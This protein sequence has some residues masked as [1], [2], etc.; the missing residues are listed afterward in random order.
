[1]YSK[2]IHQLQLTEPCLVKSHFWFNNFDNI[3]SVSLLSRCFTFRIKELEF[4]SLPIKLILYP[5]IVPIIPNR[6]TTVILESRLDREITIGNFITMLPNSNSRYPD[7][8]AI[9]FSDDDD[10]ICVLPSVNI[11]LFDTKIT[12]RV[13]I[14]ENRIQFASPLQL[15]YLG[16]TEVSGRGSTDR[17]WGSLQLTLQVVFTNDF[18]SELTTYLNAELK[19][20]VEDTVQHIESANDTLKAT[21]KQV[22]NLKLDLQK[23]Y[24][25]LYDIQTSLDNYKKRKIVL[26]KQRDQHETILY[27][28]LETYWNATD[29]LSGSIESVC[30]ITE[31][32]RACKSGPVLTLCF[33]PVTM[34]VPKFC[35]YY[36]HE[37]VTIYEKKKIPVRICTYSRNQLKEAI[38]FLTPIGLTSNRK[39]KCKRVTVYETDWEPLAHTGTVLKTRPCSVKAVKNYINETCNYTSPCAVYEVDPVCDARNEECYDNRTKIIEN[40][41][42][43]NEELLEDIRMRRHFYKLALS[44]LVDISSK[45]AILKL[46]NISKMEEIEA[47]YLKIQISQESE[48]V[49]NKSYQSIKIKNKKILLFR[50]ELKDNFNSI[51][52]ITDVS[53]DVT[54]ETQTPVIVPLNVIYEIISRRTTHEVRIVVDVSATDDLVKKTIYDNIYDD[55]IDNV[56]GGSLRK[57][58]NVASSVL[59]TDIF[60]DNCDLQRSII[61]YLEQLNL[62][63]SA[64]QEDIFDS[65]STINT[66]RE[67]E[68]SN[69]EATAEALRSIGTDLSLS[70]LVKEGM[71][72]AS[73]MEA[74]NLVSFKI[75]ETKML[76]WKAD[77]DEFHN[78]TSNLFGQT[79]YSLFDCLSTSVTN[80][81]K[82]I[83]PLAIFNNSEMAYRLN[84]VQLTVQELSINTNWTLDDMQYTI[85]KVH[86]LAIEVDEDS[87]WC[88]S[89][90]LLLDQPPVDVE[91]LVGRSLFF[92][93]P[94]SSLLPVTY[95]W[96]KNRKPIPFATTSS[97][98]IPYL[99]RADAGLYECEVKNAIGVTKSK[100]T[101]LRVYKKPTFTQEPDS[102]TVINNDRNDAYFICQANAYPLPNYQWSYRKDNYSK[103]KD[104]YG[105]TEGLLSISNVSD[106]NEGQY[107]CKAGNE[108]GTIYSK[109]VTL[110]VLPGTFTRMSYNFTITINNVD[111]SSLIQ[112]IENSFITAVDNLIDINLTPVQIISTN[113]TN[114]YLKILFVMLSS[115]YSFLSEVISNEAWFNHTIADLRQ[116]QE[117]KIALESAFHDTSHPFL[118][119]MSLSILYSIGSSISSPLIFKC[120]SGYQFD[121]SKFVCGKLY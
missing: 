32:E 30:Q 103:W 71:I 75:A 69:Y 91:D 18:I 3:N 21:S 112:S 110:T 51:I 23:L 13:Q 81:R 28:I 29:Q 119:K 45:V 58:R 99:T 54:L 97:F 27:H 43:E 104:L 36:A 93:C 77:L 68:N 86:S 47:T 83:A 116:L 12:T 102:I 105:E 24:N 94:S 42:E 82:L 34:K 17:S 63:L 9:L 53:F 117:N 37:V 38:N 44:Q 52:R 20:E 73:Q 22:S 72:Y 120:Y 16:N 85:S 56:I 46:K 59:L 61:N 111:N 121:T 118:L 98:S 11:S 95:S 31:C 89:S 66:T 108:Y 1:M 60:K 7:L 49:A 2:Y 96:Y 26:E 101:V 70:L 88:A 4:P 55:I 33:V 78:E 87:Y 74:F 5:N 67:N 8:Q 109:P 62:S 106:S 92:S 64:V 25:E 114:N 35:S 57:R 14:D 80:I 41:N 65:I 107:R 100:P 19:G 15:F 48:K 10:I 79:C 113:I 50:D 115:N 76:Q 84:D 39:L 90:P 6:V 40:F